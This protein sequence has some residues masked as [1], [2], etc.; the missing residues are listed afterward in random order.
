MSF[1]NKQ[2]QTKTQYETENQQIGR[3]AFTK[4]GDALNRYGDMASNPDTYRKNI[5]ND[6]YDSDNSA[7]W[8]D[9]QRAARRNLTNATANNYAATHGGY[10]SA[11]NKYYDDVTRRMNDYNARLWDYGVNSANTMYNSDLSNARQYYGDLGNTHDLAKTGDAIDAYNSMLKE[12]NKRWWTEPLAQV[13]TAVE[14]LAPGWWKLIGTGM[15]AGANAFSKDYSDGLARLSGQF[16]GNNDPTAFKNSATDVGGLI[17]SGVNGYMNWGGLKGNIA[18]A[19][20]QL[21]NLNSQ[22]NL[23]NA[24]AQN[25][26]VLSNMGNSQSDRNTL[27]RMFIDGKISAD[28]Y[29][30]I[31]NGGK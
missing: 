26:Q 17:S 22:T 15:K 6:Y 16:G 7:L 30:R 29:Y 25:P 10:S 18:Q 11:G 21:N 12:S 3:E 19:N 24:I 20:A 27:M 28:D 1:G 14:S 31:L 2:P 5:L 4:M 13:G 23:N 8:S 9:A